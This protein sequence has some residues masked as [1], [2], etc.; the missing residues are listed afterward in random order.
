MKKM[1]TRLTLKVQKG[2]Y[3]YLQRRLPADI[4]KTISPDVRASVLGTTSTVIKRYVGDDPKEARKK[5]A[6]EWLAIEAAFDQLRGNVEV[7][8][9]PKVDVSALQAIAWEVFTLTKEGIE[10]T[11]AGNPGFTPEALE[12]GFE[13]ACQ[14]WS[15][16]LRDNEWSRP[17]TTRVAGE[18]AE[19]GILISKDDPKFQEARRLIARAILEAHE[20]MR[21]KLDGDHT[22]QPLVKKA[23][24]VVVNP[25]EDSPTLSKLFE[26]WKAER[27][28]PPTT[29]AEFTKGIRR[30]IELHGDVLA[31]TISRS[32]VRQFK[33]AL[34]TLP[35]ALSGGQLKMT[36]PELVEEFSKNPPVKTLSPASINKHIVSVSAVLAWAGKSGYFDANPN[37][38][39]PT[40]GMKTKE[41]DSDRVSY[42]IEDL[43]TLFSSSVYSANNRPKGGGGEAAKWLPLIGLYTGARLEEIGQ[44]LTTDIRDE[45]GITFFD[46]NTLDEGKRLKTKTS[47]RKVPIHSELVRLG[48]L[49]YVEERRKSGN[50]QLFPDLRPDVKGKITGNW[51]KWYG[52]YSKKIKIKLD[53]KKV[54]HSFRHTFEDEGRAVGIGEDIRDALSGHS[55]GRIGRS[56]GDK[57]FPLEVLRDAVGKIRYE[58]LDLKHL[59]PRK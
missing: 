5:A 24:A 42:T 35:P 30:F 16:G 7:K 18:L 59:H 9:S 56:Y 15:V 13:A 52:G 51:S 4:L 41:G 20:T 22:Y 33:E 50:K 29:E 32:M 34:R 53:R 1:P 11:I 46:I 8:Q 14:D 2:R 57:Q 25:D 3:R 38:S 40:L 49:K 44:L 36:M 26:E 31:I 37:W 17:T 19:R 45:R 43:K 21:K 55:S 12:V 39:N 48:F 54:F 10:E 6:E 27:K 28:P 23:S 58:G 47:K